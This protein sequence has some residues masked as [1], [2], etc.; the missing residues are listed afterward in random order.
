MVTIDWPRSPR[1]MWLSTPSASRLYRKL[2]EKYAKAAKQPLV[3]SSPTRPRRD[4][5][6]YDT[7]L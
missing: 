1:R 5:G 6:G 4:D 7:E 2:A 3:A